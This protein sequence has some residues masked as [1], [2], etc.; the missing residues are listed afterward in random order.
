MTLTAKEKDKLDNLLANLCKK[1]KHD[2]VDDD[3]I[4]ALR[5]NKKYLEESV[6]EYVFS[7][8]ESH[9][10]TIIS[11]END[12]EDDDIDDLIDLDDSV[13]DSNRYTNGSEYI[14]AV[15]V[16]LKQIGDIPLLTA[17]EEQELAR[18][19]QDKHDIDAKNKLINSNLRLVVSVAKHY[20]AN[21]AASFNDLIQ[22][23]NIGLI[24]AVE[25]FDYNLG[26][27]FST[28]ATWWIKQAITR[29]L[30]DSLRTIRIPVHLHEQYNKVLKAHK[31]LTFELNREPTDEELIDYINKHKMLVR[32]NIPMDKTRLLEMRKI[33]TDPIS[34]YTPIGDEEDSF[35]GDFI[36]N[37]DIP[38]EDQIE[39][40]QAKEAINRVMHKVLNE[41]EIN[42]IT[43]RFGLDD[44]EAMT[45]DEIGKKFNLT[46]ERIRQIQERAIVKLNRS[47]YSKELE[48][49][50]GYNKQKVLYPRNYFRKQNKEGI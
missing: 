45:L 16:Y 4:N 22:E 41:R 26:F 6:V 23:G 2:I 24:K 7:Y 39:T 20:C 49:F 11:I 21:Q 46:R 19:Y 37:E 32:K 28:Y 31:I 34:I 29:Y 40:L 38:V 44:G 9:N 3:V 33:F 18:L 27:K 15:K 5:I 8:I 10:R 50:F 35:L 14:D 43:M 17:E 25:K 30:A 1:Y 42:I 36:P 47:K 12:I 13:Y 48:G